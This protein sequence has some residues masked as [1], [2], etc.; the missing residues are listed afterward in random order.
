[1]Y[2]FCGN[3]GASRL[4]IL[5]SLLF[6][7]AALVPGQ[8]VTVTEGTNMAATPSPGQSTIIFDLQGSLW[9]IPL[10]G[11]TAQQLT[12]PFFCPARP[13]YSPKGGLIAFSAYKS[14]P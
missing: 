9:S 7:G 12:D 4:I 1:M 11:G 3:A 8:R 13:G 10:K 6:C 14:G 5:T 2:S